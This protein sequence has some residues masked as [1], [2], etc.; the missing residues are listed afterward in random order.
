MVDPTVRDAALSLDDIEVAID[1]SDLSLSNTPAPIERPGAGES[2]AA[3]RDALLQSAVMPKIESP[4]RKKKKKTASAVKRIAPPSFGDATQREPPP[5]DFA[6]TEISEGTVL[7][8][9]RFQYVLG[10][11]LG[12]IS[13]SATHLG[14]TVTNDGSPRPVIIRRLR[15]TRTGSWPKL[16]RA[17]E[18][19][20]RA[21]V[22]L[23][24]PN[25]ARVLDAGWTED[26]PFLVRELVQ[27][28]S[29]TD[30][31]SAF[32]H[33][34]VRAVCEIIRQSALA[35]RYVH[36]TPTSVGM[37]ADAI[38]HGEI[39]ASSL[40]VGRDGRVRLTEP[41]GPDPVGLGLVQYRP[42]DVDAEQPLDETGDVY[43][44]GI[45]ALELLT[46]LNFGRPNN[47]GM[48]LADEIALRIKRRG[49]VPKE[50]VRLTMAMT[51]FQSASRPQ[52]A[53]VV[54]REIDA[55]ARQ[56]GT[57]DL[58]DAVSPILRGRTDRPNTVMGPAP[59]RPVSSPGLPVGD[60]PP[61][62]VGRL[63]GGAAVSV[64]PAP[65]S[66]RG[67]S[68]VRRRE[69]PKTGQI[70]AP[71]T[72]AP[73]PRGS[74]IPAPSTAA[75]SPRGRSIAAPTPH[76]RSIPAPSTAAPSPR[77][78]SIASPSTAAPSPRGRSIAA[79]STV[80]PSPRGR[81]IP[82]PSTVALTP[83]GQQAVAPEVDRRPA[84]TVRE[85]NHVGA[86]LVAPE[87]TN[88]SAVWVPAAPNTTSSYGSAVWSDVQGLSSVWSAG[89]QPDKAPPAEQF[90][91]KVPTAP[92]TVVRGLSVHAAA[93]RR[94]PPLPAKDARPTI[95]MTPG[96]ARR[97][98]ARLRLA[99][100]A[101]DPSAISPG[102]APGQRATSCYAAA[103]S[104]TLRAGAVGDA[105]ASAGPVSH[106]A[107]RSGA[108]SHAAPRSGAVGDAAPRSGAVGD[109]APRRGARPEAPRP[110]GARADDHAAPCARA[111]AD[112]AAAAAAV[113]M[114]GARIAGRRLGHGAGDRATG[115]SGLRPRA[116]RLHACPPGRS[117]RRPWVRRP[118]AALD[119]HASCW[120][121]GL[122]VPPRRHPAELRG[123]LAEQR[124][125][126]QPAVSR[127]G[128]EVVAGHGVLRGHGDRGG[129]R[130]R[131]LVS[132][133]FSKIEFPG[134]H[135]VVSCPRDD[136]SDRGDPRRSIDA[137]TVYGPRLG[138]DRTHR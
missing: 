65:R 1:V 64:L 44:L 9:G 50:L 115:S 101:A 128:A 81:S 14:Y 46:G 67:A 114:E 130:H 70:P 13:T 33:V 121:L 96:E 26:A 75:P 29:G 76:G 91:K 43:A 74:S 15:D 8:T 99:S 134:F 88:V 71:S 42:P 133:L 56:I 68:L 62:I 120:P 122:A 30:L 37:R 95:P 6:D 7:D 135:S 89:A 54:M 24:H 106:A 19:R 20:W 126:P 109:A 111:G 59:R 80:A 5:L 92:V 18:R 94:P 78:R 57:V 112:I 12:P 23:R 41:A 102:Y 52:T 84:M 45:T 61:M 35:L 60:E 100:R 138:P 16:T 93:P 17:F 132:A 72:V 51:Q 125:A 55:I 2:T 108:V 82:A 117:V 107:P 97:A 116:L 34:D 85:P 63:N 27:G 3:V 38:V 136:H 90:D 86:G 118:D 104:V 98:L 49:D 73:S 79:P 53:E 119:A 87:N 4:R 40:L 77:G 131:P 124:R 69:T 25:L 39:G 22:R 28:V 48:K 129:H 83:R 32:P 137:S 113:G 10:N 31:V 66:A 110:T 36:A 47:K 127:A 11:A 21:A 103:Q 123:D 105:A 58:A